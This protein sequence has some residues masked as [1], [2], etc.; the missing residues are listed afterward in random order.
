MSGQWRDGFKIK[1]KE[2]GVWSG[3]VTFRRV[4][5]MCALDN[6]KL[7]AKLRWYLVLDVTVLKKC[8]DLGRKRLPDSLGAGKDME[9]VGCLN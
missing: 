1:V 5:P 9:T 8:V 6:R 2:S 3:W 4:A 7:P